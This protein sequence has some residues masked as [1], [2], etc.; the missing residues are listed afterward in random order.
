MPS[1]RRMGYAVLLAAGLGLPT[2]AAAQPAAKMPAGFK[3]I[4]DGKTL[5]GWRGDPAFWSVKD[6]AITAGAD[7]PIVSNTYLI[8]DKPYANFELHY[9]YRFRQ[10]AG[11]SGI[12]FRSG[13]TPDGSF[14]LGG[15]QANVTPVGKPERFAMLYDEIGEK[16][17]MVLLGQ[18]ATVSR[19]Q[20]NHG[21]QGRIVRTVE[22]MVN[23]R[24]DILKA[25]HPAG[26]EWN[27]GVLIVYGNR[28]YH[29]VNGYLAFDAT[30][31]DP[32]ATKDG[33]IGIQL[34]KGP[35][36]WF[37]FKDMWIKPLTS[38]P[39]IAGRFITKPTPAA[40]PRRTYKDSTQV[41]LPDTPLP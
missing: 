19:V 33:L 41:G 1:L 37:Q 36:S 10:E 27:E 4:F 31:V 35:A 7:Q 32:L 38:A 5:N 17:E 16:Q 13:Q 11:N 21:G 3:S 28:F 25:I 24:E 2:L 18:K 40:E 26:D 23:P 34:H 30:D 12:Q 39:N 15:M 22:E 29:A 9:R 6:G 8:L 20:A 14:V